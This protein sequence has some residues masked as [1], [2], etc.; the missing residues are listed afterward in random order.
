MYVRCNIKKKLVEVFGN[1]L[2]FIAVRPN[3][4][5]VVISS[6]AIES[7]V[8]MSGKESSIERVTSYL[9]EDS[10]EYC[11]S[12]P[13]LSWAPTVEERCTENRLPPASATLF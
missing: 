5:D 13:P 2:T 6:E 9:R 3:I 1:K 12:L 4:P 8:S 7:T 10:Q 11:R